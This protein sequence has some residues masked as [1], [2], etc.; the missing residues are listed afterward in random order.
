VPGR[1]TA[2]PSAWTTAVD[3]DGGPVRVR[4]ADRG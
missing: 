3:P 4:V 1:S 2:L